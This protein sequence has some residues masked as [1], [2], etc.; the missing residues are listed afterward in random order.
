MSVVIM[1]GL[2][3]WRGDKAAR[4]QSEIERSCVTTTPRS[5][6]LPSHHRHSSNTVMAVVQ[7]LRLSAAR[8]QLGGKK[9]ATFFR[10][11]PYRNTAFPYL[12]HHSFRPKWTIFSLL[13]LNFRSKEGPSPSLALCERC[14]CNMLE[15]QKSET[16]RWNIS[17]YLCFFLS[18]CD[19]WPE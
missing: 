9:I 2:T 6:S 12:L 13:F 8:T 18:R 4:C 17:K 11:F 14:R 15:R 3:D 7:C 5:L 1:N 10:G 19:L 16:L